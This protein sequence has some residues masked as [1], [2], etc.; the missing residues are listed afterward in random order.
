M[1]LPGRLERVE[2]VLGPDAIAALSRMKVAVFGT[3]GVGGWCA[4]GLVRSGV[5]ELTIVDPD[6]IAASNINRQLMALEG[7]VGEYK[8]EVLAERLRAI[9]SS[10]VLDVRVQR[11]SAATAADF[12]L[13]RYDCVVDAIDSVADKVLLARNALS[14][15]TLALFSSMGAAMKTD[16]TKVRVSPF[17]KIEGDALARAVRGAFRRTGGIPERDFACVWSPEPRYPSPDPSAKGS[18]VQVTAVFGFALVSLVVDRAL[19][20]LGT[21]PS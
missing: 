11:Y 5:G 9:N 6:R 10:I 3:G 14:V 4:E 21:V 19:H 13:S 7:N 15:E 18:L 17:R 16:P 12:D 20:Q 8:V 2:A 1:A